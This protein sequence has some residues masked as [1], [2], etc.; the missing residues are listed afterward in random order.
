MKPKFLYLFLFIISINCTKPTNSDAFIKNVTGRY[1]YDSDQVI[2]VYFKD[3]VLLLTWKGIKDIKPMKFDD[4][5]FFVKEMNEKITFKTNPQDQKEYLVLLP[6]EKGTEI[7]FN[8]KKLEENEL[9]P[10]E[11][12]ANDNYEEALAGYIAIQQKDSLNIAVNE[13][14]MNSLGYYHLGRNETQKAINVLKINAV[15]HPNSDNV[16]DSLGEAYFKSGD[17]LQAIVNYKK[18]LAIDSGNRR[19][20]NVIERFDKK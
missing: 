17:T 10:S 18:A 14:E 13:N 19:A 9:T 11:Y 16:F 4:D 6:K 12:L 2:E 15:L 20:K 8:F 7:T 5:I 1:L 3:K